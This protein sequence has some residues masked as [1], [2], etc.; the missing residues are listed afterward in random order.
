M[1]KFRVVE[2][3]E[4]LETFEV[5]AESLEA[6]Y[7]GRYIGEAVLI[8]QNEGDYRDTLEVEPLDEAEVPAG[9][10]A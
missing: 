9:D 5:E 8:S 6:A 7:D 1:P 4:Y 2:K 10:G 3:W